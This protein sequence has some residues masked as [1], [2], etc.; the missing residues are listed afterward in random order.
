MKKSV[1][2][3]IIVAM[4][5]S[6]VPMGVL[7]A[8]ATTGAGIDC[9]PYVDWKSGDAYAELNTDNT[10]VGA[11]FDFAYKVEPWDE[12]DPSG[13]Y[14]HAGNTITITAYEDEGEYKS[15]DWSSTYP[16]SVVVVK[17]S[18]GACVYYY[19]TPRTSDTGLTAYEGRGVSHATFGWFEPDGDYCPETAWAVGDRYVNK[20]SWAMYVPYAGGGTVDIRADGGDGVGT[21]VGT[22]TFSAPVDGK[23]TITINLTGAIF[24]YDLNDL[25]YDNN[26]KVQD[27]V[28]NPPTKNPKV[29]NFAWKTMVPVGE[30]TASIEVPANNFYGVHMDL[31]VLCN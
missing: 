20:G 11:P 30:T 25:L 8:F 26:L 19:E 12:G 2:W 27:Y 28:N 1:R 7:A 21:I 13:D 9:V 14:T 3:L 16:I 15:F 4:V 31:A 22:A 29:G 24:Y 23:V 18:T 17:A 6:I 10:I 5:A